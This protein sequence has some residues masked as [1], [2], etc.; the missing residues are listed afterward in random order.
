MSR[1]R[2]G[3]AHTSAN[4]RVARIIRPQIVSPST[5]A[6]AQRACIAL[7]L[8]GVT[9]GV[10]AQ[11][12]TELTPRP[13]LPGKDVIWLGSPE[14]LVDAMLD[15]AR[16]TPQ[17]VVMDLG[18]GD[19][20][21]VITAAKRGAKAIGVEYNPDLVALS[22]RQ[23][24]VARVA[25]KATFV[26]GDL[27]QADLSAATVITLF[28]RDDLNLRLRPKLL[29]L[30]PG[31]RIVSNTFAMGDWEPDD[32]V[33]VERP[34]AQWCSAMMWIIPAQVQGTWRLPSGDMTL[35]QTFQ[36]V[37][38]TFRSGTTRTPITDGRLRGDQIMLTAGRVR[39]SGHVNGRVIEGAIGAGRGGVKWTATRVPARQ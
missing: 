35:T 19:G 32:L 39:Y 13:G 2:G 26:R 33:V 1:P 21:T 28:L 5:V 30:K 7:A 16:V 14:A 27:F 9:V 10:C 15:M 20:R 24:A 6:S 17:D 36:V 38:G 18:S 8:V 25:D 3:F 12:P 34:C 22:R 11:A 37:T 31:T 23:A 29:D 4:E